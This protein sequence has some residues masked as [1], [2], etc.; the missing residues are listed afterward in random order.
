MNNELNTI[1]SISKL[2]ASGLTPSR[3]NSK[4]WKEGTIYW[5]KSEQL[6]EYEI[7]ETNEKITQTAID[8]TSI[9][10][11]PENTISVALYGEG[12]TRGSVSILK[13]PMTTNQA[14]CNIV[15]ND[16]VAD[17]RYVYYHL[18]NNYHQLR[19][20]SSGVR[21][22]LNSDDIKNFFF[23]YKEISI[24]RKISNILSALDKKNS[25]NN[26]INA[27]LE[28]IAKT[29]YDYWFIQFDFPNDNGK[30]YKTSGGEME[31]N[32]VLEREIPK[33]WETGNI[34]SS[35]ITQ[36]IDTGIREFKDT[37]MYLSTS[38][39]ENDSIIQHNILVT[40]E[41]RPSR[42]NMQPIENSVWFARLR[43][44]KKIILIPTFANELIQNYIFST[45][46]TGLKV[47]EKA[48]Y[49]I[50]NFINSK[51]FEEIKNLN[52]TGSTQKG[53]INESIAYIPLLIPDDIILNKFNS[54]VSWLYRKKYLI[55]RENLELTQLRDFLLPLLMNGQVKI[56]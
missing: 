38:E 5:L 54:N 31:Y 2:I 48:L 21:K 32:E 27:E 17:Y 12:K 52:A 15:V 28:Q 45:G 10:I 44:T 9:K 37:K 29:I 34:A 51:Y 23:D 53:I 42:A 14:C 8:E 3:K 7:F 47:P 40:Y 39:V 50:W 46:F 55:E 11:F 24:Q 35:K 16:N 36:I 13:T 33:D 41:N 26:R 4:Y 19:N 30:P 49:Y 6:G 25:I 1:Q 56:R 22:N 18:K 43:D 20:L